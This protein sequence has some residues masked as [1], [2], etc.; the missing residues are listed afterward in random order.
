MHQLKEESYG[1][2]KGHYFT[3]GFKC[4]SLLGTKKLTTR[5]M[6]YLDID[7]DLITRLSKTGAP[8]EEKIIKKL[9]SRSMS[10]P[11]MRLS[12]NPNLLSTNH[13]PNLISIQSKNVT[14][15]VKI[16][17]SKVLL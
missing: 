13:N 6:V 4:N 16:V 7:D 5:N 2:W 9:E 1:I 11:L 15:K 3:N 10:R 12:T 8:S 14:R 17:V